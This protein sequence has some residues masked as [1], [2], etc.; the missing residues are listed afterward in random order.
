M[1]AV[2]GATAARFLAVRIVSIG[3]GLD[4]HSRE[5]PALRLCL[6]PGEPALHAL[7]G[8]AMSSNPSYRPRDMRMTSSRALSTTHRPHGTSALDRRYRRAPL[9]VTSRFKSLGE[10]QGTAAPFWLT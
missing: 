10:S 3:R 4:P 9:V 7:F 8:N 1:I 6:A 5:L 2:N